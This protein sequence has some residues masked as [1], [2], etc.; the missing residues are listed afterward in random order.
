LAGYYA[1]VRRRPALRFYDTAGPGGL[2]EALA[3]ATTDG[4]QML[5]GPLP[6]DDVNTVI[7]TPKLSL[8]T[9][10]LNRGGHAP[11]PGSASFALAP[12][13]EG[14]AAAERLL[15][16]GQRRVLVVTQADDTARRGLDSFRAHLAA[17]GGE[18]V[19][20]V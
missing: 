4:A 19:G 11:P 9:V 16:R 2:R 1:E 8:P 13:D 15:E 14:I 20:E 17:R 5:I 3:R 18:V 12:E 6:R 7:P 10:E